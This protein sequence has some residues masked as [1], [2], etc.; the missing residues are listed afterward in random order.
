MALKDAEGAPGRSAGPGATTP[1]DASARHVFLIN[2][3]SSVASALAPHACAAKQAQKVQHSW[4]LM[5][6]GRWRLAGQH[7]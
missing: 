4:W 1:L 3:L 2:C 5:Q 6:A 7:V